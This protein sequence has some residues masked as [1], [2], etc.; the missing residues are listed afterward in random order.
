MDELPRQRREACKGSNRSTIHDDEAARTVGHGDVRN[1]SELEA[2]I[3]LTHCPQCQHNCE[4][5]QCASPVMHHDCSRW[6]VG[7]DG[8]MMRRP[9]VHSDSSRTSH[10]ESS[11]VNIF[12]S[13][14]AREMG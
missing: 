5:K 13:L 11:H 1:R 12:A 10:A 6:R 2:L 3:C 9:D 14:R 8:L 7:V 4:Y